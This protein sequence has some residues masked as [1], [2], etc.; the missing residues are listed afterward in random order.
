[1]STWWAG[2]VGENLSSFIIWGDTWENDSV[3]SLSFMNHEE[4]GRGEEEE[5]K[6]ERKVGMTVPPVPP[7]NFGLLLAHSE[8]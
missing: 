2:G 1:M 8:T 7:V 5:E 6:E 4:G 3:Y